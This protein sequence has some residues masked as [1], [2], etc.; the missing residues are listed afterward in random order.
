MPDAPRLDSVTPGSATAGTALTLTG[1]FGAHTDASAVRF[2]VPV[3]GAAPV[4]GTIDDWSETTIHVHLPSLTSFGSGGPLEITVH[5]DAGDSTAVPFLLEEDSP[6]S[7]AGVN[8]A[9]GLQN[10]TITV[11]GQG[12]GR[13]GTGSAALFQAPGPHDVSAQVVDWS[14]TSITVRVPSL[15]SLGGS[16]D[17]SIVVSVPWGRSE[18]TDFLL[19]ELPQVTAVLPASPAPG[20]T[21]TVQGRA[22]GPQASGALQLADP[23]DANNGNHPAIVSWTDTEVH[24]RLPELVGL[25]T[26]GSRDVVV[27]S[28]WGPSVPDQHSRILIESRASITAW[29]RLEPHARTEDLQQGLR[30][31]LQAQVY[32]ALWLLGRQWQL[33]EL[34]GADAGSPVSVTVAGTTTPLARWR[35][36]GGQPYDVPAGVPLDALVERERVMPP[37]GTGTDPFND[38]RLAAEAGLHLLRLIEANLHDPSRIDDYRARFLRQYPIEAPADVSALDADTRRF[39]AVTAGRVPDGGRV[40]ADFQ[41]VLGSHP[42]L[43]KQPPID[44]NDRAAV[45]AAVQQWYAWCA[46]LISEPVPDAFAWDRQRMEYAFS[47][48]SGDLVLDA[49]QHDGGHLDWYS[50][51][52]RT[53]NSDTS[54]GAAAAGRG[55]TSFTRTVVPNAVSF[56]GMPVPRWWELE[57]GRVDFGSVAAAPNELLTLVLV[58]FTTV[59]GND[60]FTV[61]LDALPVG[62]L[63]E[64]TTVT[65]TDA[66]GVSTRVTPFGNGAGTDWRMFEVTR[67]DGAT[68]SGNA[69]LLLDALPTTHESPPV[70]EIVLLRDE[71]ANMAWAVEK[72]VESR[73]GRPMDRHEDEASR[74]AEPTP[75]VDDELRRYVLQTPVPRQWIPLLPRYDRD[76]AGAVA[77]RWLARGA[78]RDAADGTP[79]SPRGRLLEPGTPLDI[80][81]EEVPR[82]GI[83]LTRL[84]TLGRS[85]N[86]QTHLWRGRRKDSGRGEG[87]SGLRF[88]DTKMP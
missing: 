53:P 54:L 24:A 60:W 31:G 39:L 35:P 83:R 45:L 47:V 57:D 8:P 52:R 15:Q 84:W 58:E 79:I 13:P 14:P 68:D 82:A 51:I 18:A 27:T 50:F 7:V 26:T 73:T 55:P 10:D 21:I 25:R 16:G 11:T 20:T 32:D 88:D 33:L 63:C 23:K 69:L 71:L 49:P 46:D 56:P 59:Y 70:E 19:G 5:T 64:L 87:S 72:T 4:V 1:T 80:F 78:M 67:D 86:G 12:F 76:D 81:D 2:R 6:P 66:F 29:T 61:P 40:Y 3:D 9:R 28:E 34:R 41:T 36:Y 42:T 22:F 44:G 74:R 38:L 85:T 17:R 43:P 75:S 77:M 30:L 62:A 65:V 37:L 48:G